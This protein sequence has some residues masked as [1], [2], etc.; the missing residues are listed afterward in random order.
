MKY[1]E[2]NRRSSKVYYYKHKEQVCAAVKKRKK[3]LLEWMLQ[4]KEQRGCL[5]CGETHPYCLEFHH[6]DIKE[7]EYLV[8]DLIRHGASKKLIL[9][10][11]DKCILL[12]ANCHRK[13]H[14]PYPK[15]GV[16]VV[17]SHF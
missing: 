14:N 8:S 15:Y 10:E 5:K 11:I 1:A 12:C 3:Q 2:A 13:F 6:P 9:R 17:A 16:C 4:Y 7:K